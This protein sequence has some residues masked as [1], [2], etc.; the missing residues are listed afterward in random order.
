MLVEPRKIAA[1]WREHH[2]EL[3]KSL[4]DYKGKAGSQTSPVLSGNY[5]DSISWEKIINALRSAADNKAPGINGIPAEV[6]KIL[7][8]DEQGSSPLS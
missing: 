4:E 6:Y 7:L 5:N 8:V 3:A 1:R 2:E